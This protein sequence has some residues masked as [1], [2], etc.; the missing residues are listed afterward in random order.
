M[1]WRGENAVKENRTALT[2]KSFG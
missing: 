2:K 1:G